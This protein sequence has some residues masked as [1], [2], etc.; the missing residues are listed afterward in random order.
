MRP[1]A[2]TSTIY[3]YLLIID[4]R[5]PLRCNV[6]IDYQ[7][8]FSDSAILHH[9]SERLHRSDCHRGSEQHRVSV[10]L[11]HRGLPGQGQAES[12]RE[13]SFSILQTSGT[14]AAAVLVF[15]PS[16]HPSYIT[17]SGLGL[18]DM[19][20]QHNIATRNLGKRLKNLFSK[21]PEGLQSRHISTTGRM[22]THISPCWIFKMWWW[23]G[24]NK[25]IRYELF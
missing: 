11:H 18:A 22:L 4:F 16:F 21:L 25:G 19:K 20:T 15:I 1:L 5:P 6:T 13:I 12:A 17:V 8:L 3:S 23:K 7:L 9:S 24:I 14:A 10:S 2:V